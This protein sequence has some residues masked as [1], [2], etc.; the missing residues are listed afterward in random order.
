MQAR[1]QA[2]SPACGVEHGH[3][4][5]HARLGCIT[6][7]LRSHTRT[8]YLRGTGPCCCWWSASL[9]FPWQ[10]EAELLRFS[11]AWAFRPVVHMTLLADVQTPTFR[12]YTDTCTPKDHPDSAFCSRT[13]KSHCAHMHLNIVMQNRQHLLPQAHC[14]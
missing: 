9:S 11:Y 8:A 7:W 5:H 13:C 10:S 14:L 2:A 4:M 1:M 12:V 3:R 6:A